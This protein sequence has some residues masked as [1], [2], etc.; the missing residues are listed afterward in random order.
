M[1]EWYFWSTRVVI[2]SLNE[3]KSSFSDDFVSL[4]PLLRKT[5]VK[6]GEKDS[7]RR[8]E[9]NE[10][11][12][13]R[14]SHFLL[15]SYQDK[16]TLNTL[17]HSSSHSRDQKISLMNKLSDLSPRSP[18]QATLRYGVDA[19]LLPS[20]SRRLEI[21]D[22]QSQFQFNVSVTWYLSPILAPLSLLLLH[23]SLKAGCLY[24]IPQR[25]VCFI[26]AFGNYIF[27]CF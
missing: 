24:R 20:A 25:H 27:F 19:T 18:C 14:Q 2:L 15:R 23:S 10:A 16:Y 6:E 26:R 17:A 11:F 3:P 7:K 4:V 9:L 5:V 21:F 12:S 8:E 13:Y 22:N 1:L